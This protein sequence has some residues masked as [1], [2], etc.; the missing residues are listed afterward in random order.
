MIVLRTGLTELGFATHPHHVY[1]I[2]E[3][4]KKAE[5]ATEAVLFEWKLLAFTRFEF[6]QKL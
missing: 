5:G 4:Q 3:A 6:A 2:R 1:G